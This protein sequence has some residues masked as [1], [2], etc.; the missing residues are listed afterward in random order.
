MCLCIIIHTLNIKSKAAIPI[1][2]NP[3]RLIKAAAP[4]EQALV[5][6]GVFYDEKVIR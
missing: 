4:G 3:S 6:W 1:T 5:F 2:S